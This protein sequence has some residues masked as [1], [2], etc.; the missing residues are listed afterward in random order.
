MMKVAYVL[1]PV[2]FGGAEKVSAT[3]L[4]HADRTALDISLVPLVRP[5]EG[6]NVF[7]ECVEGAGYPVFPIPVA[8][9]PPGEGRDPFRVQRSLVRLYRVL[10]AQP[11][12]LV[13][14]HGYFADIIA[15]PLCRYLRIPHIATCHG[16]IPT[17]G[18][19]SLYNRLD[20]LAL[21][22]CSRIIAVADEIR[23]EL[24]ASGIDRAKVVV[25]QNAVGAT[26]GSSPAAGKAEA[27]KALGLDPDA[28]IVGYAG[29]LSR[30]KGVEHLLRAA[31]ALKGQGEGCVVLLLGDGPE[32]PALEGLARSLGLKVVFAGFRSDVERWLSA[33]DVFA[34]PSLTEGT[35]LALLEAMSLGVPVVASAVGGVPGVVQDGVSGFLVEPGD[36]LGMGERIRAYRRDPLLGERMSARAAATVRERFEVHAWCS[37]IVRQYREVARRR[38]D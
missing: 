18:S 31:R 19:L 24:V 14:T 15:A 28:F 38:V 5:W 8:L 36:H 16:Y 26:R 30:E 23:D 27:R 1:T 37:R 11:F 33:M 4:L 34:L 12:D 20:R 17:G 35:P 7:L 10:T 6:G 21:R 9:R 22:L 3:F 13:H 32:R 29:R 25:I 2:E